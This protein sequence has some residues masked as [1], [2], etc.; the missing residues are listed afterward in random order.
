MKRIILLIGI[1]VLIITQGNSQIVLKG[2]AKKY[3]MGT[4]SK[5]DTVR[6]YG[7][8]VNLEN[9]KEKYLIK[10]L[11]TN[12]YVNSEKVSL[13]DS[14]LDFW[15]NVW[16]ETKGEYYLKYGWETSIRDN[17]NESATEY[18]N[19]AKENDFI[20]KDELFYEY[21][22]HLLVK[23]HPKELIKPDS[24]N[25]RVVII[26]SDQPEYFSFDNG[27]I[28][29]TTETISKTKKEVQLM[30]IL[31]ECISHIV[32][33]T[34]LNNLRKQI[35]AERKANFWGAF[36]TIVSSVAMISSNITEGT[37]YTADDAL[38]FG[39][40]IH[41]LS[42]SILDNI[43]ANYSEQQIQ[44]AVKTSK[45]YLAQIDRNETLSDDEYTRRISEV[46]SF[47]AL[48]EYHYKNY[49]YVVE[50][51]NR[52]IAVDEAIE[53][54]YLLLSKIYRAKYNTEEYNLKALNLIKKAKELG[55]KNLIELDKEAG[56]LYL[57]LKD[58]KNAKAS[59]IKYK[60]GLLEQEKQGIEV[61]KELKYII[62]LTDKYKL[63]D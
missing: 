14:E 51:L 7:K 41:F 26:K 34:N 40:S 29:L 32:M 50:L 59:F 58:Y 22:N 30:A 42:S 52:I 54:D 20:F 24:T 48:M 15:E 6:V 33:E 21:I 62:Q 55:Y 63:L 13:P 56:L 8:K 5:G 49:D 12:T 4:Y 45:A 36:A 17:L 3:I 38:D 43:G 2:V 47:T 57:R 11:N 35:K 44:T 18:Y 31:A 16:F 19:H 1:L 53:E 9:S 60:N 27:L 61:S 25:L 10:G 28:V 39:N 23:I 46:L 37:N